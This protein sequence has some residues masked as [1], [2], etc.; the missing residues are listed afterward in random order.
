[1]SI[2]EEYFIKEILEKAL[3]ENIDYRNIEGKILIEVSSGIVNVRPYYGD[4]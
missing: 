4:V 2:S 3:R 1:M